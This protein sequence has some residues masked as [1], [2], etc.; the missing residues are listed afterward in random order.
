MHRRACELIFQRISH[1]GETESRGLVEQRRERFIVLRRL[2]AVV[3]VSALTSAGCTSLRT[4]GPASPGEPPF[5]PVQTGDTVVVL[6]RSGEHA[7]FVVQG[8]D[9]ETLIAPNGRRY[10]RS[11][12]VRVEHKTLDR[13]K[14]A[15]LIAGIAGGVF[16]VVAITVGAWL[17]KN[18]R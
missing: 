1:A 2:I 13:A 5:G 7:T 17:G 14:T 12:L 10:V 9:G 15:G 4:I 3:L 18:S 16:V 8:I 11:D 6:T